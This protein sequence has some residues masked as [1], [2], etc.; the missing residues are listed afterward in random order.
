MGDIVEGVMILNDYGLIAQ[1]SWLWP[2]ERDD[3]VSL[4]EYVIMPNHMHGIVVY[5]DDDGRGASR[6]ALEDGSGTCARKVTIISA[7]FESSGV[8]SP[9]D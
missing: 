2:A 7:F 4:D 5:L 9:P 3:Y 6:C 8:I 1:E